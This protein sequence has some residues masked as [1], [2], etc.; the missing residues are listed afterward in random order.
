MS[1]NEISHIAGLGYKKVPNS[2]DVISQLTA[3]LNLDNH[4]PFLWEHLYSHEKKLKYIY[5]EELKNLLM[6]LQG[7]LFV[8]PEITVVMDPPEEISE[9]VLSWLPDSQAYTVGKREDTG[10]FIVSDINKFIKDIGNFFADDFYI[11]DD[12]YSWIIAITH[13]EQNENGDKII[14]LN[15][16][17]I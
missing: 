11:F 12:S 5:V 2:Q 8:F 6:S 10:V 17:H 15:H 13:E 1:A 7:P 14:Y 3:S 9:E 4:L 16:N